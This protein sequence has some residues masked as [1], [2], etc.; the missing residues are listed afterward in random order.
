M[1]TENQPQIGA[2]EKM[3]TEDVEKK[4]KVEFEV[5]KEV[6]VTLLGEPNEF[7]GENGAYYIFPVKQGEEEKVIITSAWTLL[8]GL[9]KLQP[10][11]NKKVK[12]TKVMEK[13]KQSFVVTEE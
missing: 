4:P 3:T 13:G 2:W 12:I 9:K 8:K 7:Q 5:G 1:Q 10:L 11:S 6:S